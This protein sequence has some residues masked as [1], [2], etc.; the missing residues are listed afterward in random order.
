[1]NWKIKLETQVATLIILMIVTL[2]VV[3]GCGI[4]QHTQQSVTVQDTVVITKE[5]TLHDTLTV[6]KD[7][8]IYQ[9]R[10]KVEVKWLEGERVFV[11]AE[12]PTDTIRVEKIKIVNQK[13]VEKRRGWEFYAGLGI[14]I[15]FLLVIVKEVVGKVF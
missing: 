6:Q 3:S 10:V 12:C 15:L 4:A 14:S 2:V 11:N 5:R 13:I 1:M 8:I 9:D 7:T